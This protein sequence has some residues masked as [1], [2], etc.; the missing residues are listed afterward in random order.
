MSKVE[1]KTI[2]LAVLLEVLALVVLSL[3]QIS[4]SGEVR[5][6]FFIGSVLLTLAAFGLLVRDLNS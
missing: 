1:I 3:T 6:G 5:A 4:D 2:I